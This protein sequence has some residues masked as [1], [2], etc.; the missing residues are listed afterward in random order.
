M[1]F[2]PMHHSGTRTEE[3][4]PTFEIIILGV[5]KDH[6][7]QQT[8]RA[9]DAINSESQ[10]GVTVEKGVRIYKSS[11]LPC[12]NVTLELEQDRSLNIVYSSQRSLQFLHSD[13]GRSRSNTM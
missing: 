12:W 5:T 1:A 2:F 9:R 3:E 11:S 7:F 4:R 13:R 6:D 8:K 10:V